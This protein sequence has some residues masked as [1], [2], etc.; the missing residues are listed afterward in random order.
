M[1]AARYGWVRDLPDIRDQ[2][3]ASSWQT[4]LPPFVRRPLLMP[5][6]YDQGTIQSC[7]GNGTAR[8]LQYCRRMQGLPDFVPSR[9]MLYYD[10]RDREGSTSVDCGAQIRDAIKGAAEN[11]ACPET[12]W[13]YDSGRVC[14]RPTDEAYAA[15]RKDEAIGYRRVNQ[16]LNAVRA[17]LASGDPIVFGFTVYQSFEEGDVSATG[18]MQMP[19]PSEGVLG[20]HCVVAVGYDNS[21]SAVYVDNSW[22]SGWGL[23]GSF[24]MPYDYITNPQ[25]CSDMWTIRL[26]TQPWNGV[27]Q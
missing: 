23:D 16:T 20:G 12:M 8:A 11:G 14:V 10:A 21:K 3:Y 19:Q 4:E 15:G 2:H 25:L 18:V 24:W 6:I 5:P 13:M 1:Q 9:L 22:G 17:C 26:V 7:T 27:A